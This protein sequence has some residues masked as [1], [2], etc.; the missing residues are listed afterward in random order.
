[1]AISC[2]LSAVERGLGVRSCVLAGSHDLGV[3]MSGVA[4]SHDLGVRLCV[5]AGSRDL[6]M[7]SRD[8][9]AVLHDLGVRSCVLAVSCDC[10]EQHDS[11]S[12]SLLQDCSPNSP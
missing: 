8:L 1:M 7:L 3:L 6:G 4:E 11:T 10:A 12:N 2:D 9:I 5:L